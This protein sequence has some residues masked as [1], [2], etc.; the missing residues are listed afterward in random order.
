V[1]S[2]DASPLQQAQDSLQALKDTVQLY[3]AMNW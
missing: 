2:S 1:K 3:A